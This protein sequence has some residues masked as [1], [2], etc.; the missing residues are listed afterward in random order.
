MGG[1]TVCRTPTASVGAV[2]S[3]EF[4]RTILLLLISYQ[5]QTQTVE[6]FGVVKTVL[7]GAVCTLVSK[8]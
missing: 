6:I 7:T 8:F 3:I 1:K 4:L 2:S 5:Q